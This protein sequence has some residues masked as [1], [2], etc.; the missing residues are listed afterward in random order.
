MPLFNTF[1]GAS[2]TV[3]LPALGNAVVGIMRYWQIRR[4]E[5]GPSAGAYSLRA[6]LTYVNPYLMNDKTLK[7]KIIVDIGKMPDGRMKRYRVIW[8]DLT[9]NEYDLRLTRAEFVPED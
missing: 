7:K 3:T 4:E 8:E 2:G 1:Q 6:S 9:L 5:S